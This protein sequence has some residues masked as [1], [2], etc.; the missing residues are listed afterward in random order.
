MKNNLPGTGG[1][2]MI[3]R[4]YL[5]SGTN[6]ENDYSGVDVKIYVNSPE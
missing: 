6:F 5:F 1:K 2:C 4:S 3:R